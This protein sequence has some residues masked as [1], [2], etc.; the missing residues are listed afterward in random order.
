MML[1]IVMQSLHCNGGSET[2]LQVVKP[3]CE[4]LSDPMG[5]GV[6]NPRFS[7]QIVATG[8]GIQQTAYRVLVSNDSIKLAHG[9]ADY[10]DS[11][12]IYSSKS[13]GIEYQGSE[14]KSRKEYFW[15]VILWD[16]RDSPA[17]HSSVARFETGIFKLSEW[18]GDWISDG[19]PPEHEPAPYFRKEFTSRRSIA[20]ARLYICGLGYYELHM[21]GQKVG[22]QHLAPAFSRFDK[23]SY[24]NT[25]DVRSY[26]NQGENVIG[27]VLGNGWY[28]EQSKAVWYFHEAPWRARPK[29]LLNLYIEYEDGDQL[30]VTSDTTWNVSEGPIIFNNIYSGE[31]Y[32]AR[33]EIH[34]WDNTG[35]DDAEWGKALFPDKQNAGC[36][37]AQ[38]VQPIRITREIDPVSVTKFSEKEYLFDFGQNFAGFS[39]ISVSGE[40]GTLLVIRHGEVLDESGHLDNTEISRHC[41]FEDPTEQVQTD[42]LIL[43]GKETDMFTQHFTYHGFRYLEVISDRPVELHK[44]SIKGLVVHTDVERTGWLTTG[45]DLMN[46]IFEAGIWSYISNLHGIPTDCPHRE[47]NGWTGDGHISA[48]VGF[49]NYDVILFYEK[50]IRDFVDE[51]QPTGELPAIVPTSG[52]G[53]QWGNGPSW[54]SGFLLVPWYVYL[55]YG[56]DQLI[57]KYYDRYKRYMDYLAFRAKGHVLDF[58]LGDWRSYKTETPVSFTSTCYYFLD[59]VLMARFA[60]L[61]G[62]ENDI[63]HYENLAD[64]IREAINMKF[65]YETEGIYANGS[66]TALSAALYQGV[67]PEDKKSCVLANLE[68]RIHADNDHLDVGLLGSKYLLNALTDNELSELAYTIASRDTKPS[69]GWWIRQGLTTFQEGWGIGPSRNHIYKGEILAWMYKALAGINPDPE[70]PGFRNIIIKPHFVEG[71]SHVKARYESVNGLIESEWSNIGDR[72][73]LRITVPANTQAIVYLPDREGRLIYESGLPTEHSDCV[74][75]A[76]TTNE[77]KIFLVGSGDYTFEIK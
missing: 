27:V 25:Y 22:Q 24:Y 62:R 76:G 51:Q 61:A 66:Q 52:W 54:D 1:L 11:G 41:R 65:Y 56:D 57:R 47:K 13:N 44:Y 39:R 77:H 20:R 50:W 43:S 9:M 37:E 45:S 4:Y 48:E 17:A 18:E 60:E 67:V 23:T 12:K 16:N 70:N 72:T 21:N 68:N 75:A 46:R 29:L 7:W 73:A 30:L 5:I 6:K 71:L 14:L 53:Y 63:S 10:W 64:S 2:D 40:R 38:M 74:E 36:L 15:K 58:G 31:Y 55:Y 19:K 8:R 35:F 3:R 26:L 32:D 42:R 33:N 34:G 69:W 49:Y 28:N 59:A